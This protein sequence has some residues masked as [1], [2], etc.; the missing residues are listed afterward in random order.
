MN[1]KNLIGKR[2]GRLVVIA[3]IDAIDLVMKLHNLNFI[4]AVK[5]L[6]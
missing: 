4:Q 6:Q 5:K 3:E 1:K 2:F